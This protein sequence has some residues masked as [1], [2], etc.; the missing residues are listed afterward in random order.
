MEKK[1]ERRNK[2]GNE[3]R[4]KERRKDMKAKREARLKI[5]REKVK[6]KKCNK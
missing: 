3:G 1:A 4:K 2:I 5:D 6:V